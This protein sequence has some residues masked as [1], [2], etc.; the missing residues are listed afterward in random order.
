MA[1]VPEEDTRADDRKS[2]SVLKSNTRVPLGIRVFVGIDLPDCQ[3]DKVANSGKGRGKVARLLAGG[4][5]TGR[6][7]FQTCYRQ[8]RPAN[9]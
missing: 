1:R 3:S 8:D 4:E 6:W 9:I 7:N 5:C 2:G